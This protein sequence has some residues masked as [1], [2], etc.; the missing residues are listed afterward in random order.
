MRLNVLW[1]ALC[2]LGGSLFF[3]GLIVLLVLNSSGGLY[4]D[5]DS[6]CDAGIGECG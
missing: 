2:F 4:E 5:C 6:A 3:T 1:A